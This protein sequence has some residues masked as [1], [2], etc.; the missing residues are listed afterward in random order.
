[1]DATPP[2]LPVA[3]PDGARQPNETAQHVD[4]IVRLLVVNQPASGHRVVSREML[5]CLAE[6]LTLPGDPGQFLAQPGQ[7]GAFVIA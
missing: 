6:H 2:T 4:R 7:F 5:P 3:T 1:M